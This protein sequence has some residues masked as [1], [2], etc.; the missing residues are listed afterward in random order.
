LA[1]NPPARLKQYW[2]TYP[3]GG[4]LREYLDLDRI[5]PPL[6]VRG[7]LPGD[8]YRP[9]SMA[10]SRKLKD[11][12]IDAKLPLSLRDLVPVIVSGKNIIWLIGY[13]PAHSYRIRKE[14]RMILELS[15]V[16]EIN[17]SEPVR[18]KFSILS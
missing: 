3:Q 1:F 12:F 18:E 17:R 8:R 6:V 13:R 7:R 5:V 15:L 16:P 9:F 11:I 10:G 14:T 4:V 2:E